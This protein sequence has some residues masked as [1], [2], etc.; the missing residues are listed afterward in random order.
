[1]GGWADRPG[2][3]PGAAVGID[4]E[5]G[6]ARAGRPKTD[7]SGRRGASWGAGC[8]QLWSTKRSLMPRAR[9]AASIAGGAPDRSEKVCVSALSGREIRKQ[10]G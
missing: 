7:A 9:A 2:L 6:A 1:M 4:R 10:A 8:D 5:E 3:V